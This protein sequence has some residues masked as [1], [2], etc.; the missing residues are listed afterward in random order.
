MSATFPFWVDCN[1][2]V[3]HGCMHP[4]VVAKSSML[5]QVE[6][7]KI[8]HRESLF[9]CPSLAWTAIAA[10]GAQFTIPASSMHLCFV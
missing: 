9:R 8:P 1:Q 6:H 10:L 4:A 2:S 5:P 3:L 7:P